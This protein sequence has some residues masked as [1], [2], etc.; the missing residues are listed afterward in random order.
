MDVYRVAPLAAPL[1]AVVY[2]PGSKSVANRVL[3]CTA[4]AEG[5][6]TVH[7]VPSG[8]DTEAML[9]C[10]RVLGIE[11]DRDVDTGTVVVD[12][13]RSHLRKGPLTLPTRIAG[14]TSRFLTALSALGPRSLLP[15]KRPKLLT[16]SHS[17]NSAG[18]F[19]C[20][21]HGHNS[22]HGRQATAAMASGDA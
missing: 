16:I 21:A 14:T 22:S 18:D 20:S 11:A 10:L 1:D 17:L 13:G 15:R 7:D 12:G 4:L 3:V 2:V 9:D 8:D 6:S 5:R 19:A